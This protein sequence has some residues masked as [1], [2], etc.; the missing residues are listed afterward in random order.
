MKNRLL[1]ESVVRKFMKLARLD[2]SADSF[3]E[4][5]L[6]EMD[7]ME[8]EEMELEE[9]KAKVVMHGDKK[10]QKP[11]DMKK[12]PGALSENDEELEDDDM[13]PAP[14]SEAPPAPEPSVDDMPPE[15]DAAPD[16]GPEGLLKKVVQAVADA[17]GV[18][19]S[20]DGEMP[21]SDDLPGED[22]PP[23][24]DAA[25]APAGEEPLDDE[26]PM[27]GADL[28]KATNESVSKSDKTIEEI[29]RRVAQRLAGKK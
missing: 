29:S 23:P 26:M 18:D 2:E 9:E 12:E 11:K 16:E 10:D 20:I 1:D 3:V 22:M 17:L 4:K 7:D 13:P 8:P 15:P 28:A 6:S 25:A 24:D 27:E 19:V 14:P 21:D 5:N